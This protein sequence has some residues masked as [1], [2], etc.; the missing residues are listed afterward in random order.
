MGDYRT[1]FLAPSGS[2]VIGAGTIFNLGGD[3]FM[4]NGSRSAAEADARALRCDWSIVGRDIS[5]A[6]HA[7]QLKKLDSEKTE[8]G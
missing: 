5:S 3:S 2:L 1:D 7:E 4:V 6:L 8:E